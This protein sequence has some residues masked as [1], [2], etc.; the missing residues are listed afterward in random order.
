MTFAQILKPHSTMDLE[1]VRKIWADMLMVNP[2][3]IENSD[4]FFECTLSPEESFI[5]K[6]KANKEL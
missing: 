3:D 2:E 5:Q 6:M 4:D 1:Q